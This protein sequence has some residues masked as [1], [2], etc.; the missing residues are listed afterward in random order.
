MLPIE[1]IELIA[2]YTAL[3]ARGIIY[4]LIDTDFTPQLN[5][6][7]SA[8]SRTIYDSDIFPSENHFRLHAYYVDRGTINIV[9]CDIYSVGSKKVT[10]F[11][12]HYQEEINNIKL[13]FLQNSNV[14]GV[15]DKREIYHIVPSN[16][17]MIC[18]INEE[19]TLTVSNSRL[20]LDDKNV[21]I[22]KRNIEVIEN[23]EHYFKVDMI[24]SVVDFP[25]GPNLFIEPIQHYKIVDNHLITLVG[26]PG[27]YELSH[28]MCF[29]GK[30]QG[31]LIEG[32]I[33]N[34]EDVSLY[35]NKDYHHLLYI[36]D[37]RLHLKKLYETGIRHIIID[38]INVHRIFNDL[39]LTTEG[40]FVTIF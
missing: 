4:K 16:F 39:I 25:E 21:I 2:S 31:N 19:G 33:K 20:Y 36:I 28:F 32:Y 6:I 38:N 34:I 1:L 30:T 26:S 40:N 13:L 35:R 7:T 9:P 23:K 15:N 12:G 14:Y 37:G 27:R 3:K 10:H 8:V 11:T 17:E 5:T 22:K 29:N 24:N 18:S